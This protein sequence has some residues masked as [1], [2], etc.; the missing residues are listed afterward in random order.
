MARTMILK[1]ACSKIQTLRP[2]PPQ[3]L[4][5]PLLVRRQLARLERI[6]QQR[7]GQLAHRIR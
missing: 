2:A 3:N 4:A 6:S 5:R 7:F 1:M